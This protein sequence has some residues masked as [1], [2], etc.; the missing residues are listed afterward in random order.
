[1]KYVPI[2]DV[3]PSE[4]SDF[5]PWLAQ[6]ENLDK[7]SDKIGIPFGPA[8][9]EVPVGAYRADIFT[10]ENSTDG[11]NVIIENQYGQT[12]HDHLGKIITYGSGK[13]EA[14]IGGK[15]VK[16]KYNVAKRAESI[17][18]GG[19]DISVFT[20]RQSDIDYMVETAIESELEE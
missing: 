6:P 2:R 11:R 16:S 1:M 20:N 17:F 9:V 10:T 13:T 5:T 19:M 4:S 12:N 3:W 8:T 15:W 18:D 7:L 14:F